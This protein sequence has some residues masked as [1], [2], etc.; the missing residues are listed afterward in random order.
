MYFIA[1]FDD[2]AFRPFT[3]RFETA[4][5]VNVILLRVLHSAMA[6]PLFSTSFK[7]IRNIETDQSTAKQ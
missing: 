1:F 3:T 5:L 4:F 7:C 2:K 6:Y